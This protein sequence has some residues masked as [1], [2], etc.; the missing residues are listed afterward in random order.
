MRAPFDRRFEVRDVCLDRRVAFIADRS[1]ADIGI[2]PAATAATAER[3]SDALGPRVIVGESKILPAGRAWS[4]LFAGRG[5]LALEAVKSFD[6][7][8]EEARFALLAVS[9][10]IDARFDL[11]VADAPLPDVLT[12][13]R[14]SWGIRFPGSNRQPM[15]VQFYLVSSGYFETL[16]M[17]LVRGR[18]IERRDG[19]F[20]VSR[21]SARAA[22]NYK[23]KPAG[24]RLSRASQKLASH[25]AR[26]RPNGVIEA[27]IGHRPAHGRSP[28]AHRLSPT[29][30]RLLPK[31][32]PDP[33]EYD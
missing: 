16:G 10:N 4:H 26:P 28:T 25:A 5:R 3:R 8:G 21:W 1:G 17:R 30:H 6:D 15:G 23:G 31:P 11:L 14:L 22:G 13:G 20:V 19:L 18:G 32:A 29:A 27:P 24:G 33:K 7:I 2:P 9:D 12:G